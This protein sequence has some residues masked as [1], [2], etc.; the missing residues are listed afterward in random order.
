M[1][2]STRGRYAVMAMT[3]LAQ[4]YLLDIEAPQ[5]PPVKLASIAERQEISLLYLE[6]IFRD[7]RRAGLVE[8]VRGPKG[9]YRLSRPPEQLLV[10]DIIDSVD[11]N[12]N[13]TRC[14]TANGCLAKQARCMTHALWAE[15]GGHIHAFLRRISL[16]DVVS[17]DFTHIA[18][19]YEAH[20][21][22]H[23]HHTAEQP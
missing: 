13:V 20:T 6:Q 5:A 9:G 22:Q 18:S 1:K 2:L 21:P 15:L 4:H 19:I 11:E 10:S 16:A 7:L 17:S 14:Q 12:I 8:S 3:D 23:Q